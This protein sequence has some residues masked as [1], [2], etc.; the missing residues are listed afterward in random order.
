MYRHH[1]EEIEQAVIAYHLRHGGISR[2]RK[3]EYYEGT[4]LGRPVTEQRLEQLGHEFQDRVLSAVL[5]AR[6]IDGAE[7]ILRHLQAASVPMY[8]V[9]GTPHEELQSIVSERSIADYFRRVQ[10]APKT[11]EQI[12]LEILEEDQLQAPRCL[13]VGDAMS[14]LEAAEAVGMAFLGIVERGCASPFPAHVHSVASL[15]PAEWDE[16]GVFDSP[17]ITQ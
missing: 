1:G 9:S 5:E 13:F 2:Y 16:S 14:D 8:I 10:G 3:F 12:L 6:F 17:G 7:A 15:R 11:K 4:L